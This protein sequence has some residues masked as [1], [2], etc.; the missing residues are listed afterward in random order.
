[1]GRRP[2]L[3]QHG[4]RRM[5]FALV[6]KSSW[7]KKANCLYSIFQI[8]WRNTLGL[9]GG[10]SENHFQQVLWKT[11]A[12]ESCV[13]L[14]YRIPLYLEE[15]NGVKA[16]E[17][18]VFHDDFMFAA[19]MMD[20]ENWV[21]PWAR[22]AIIARWMWKCWEKEE[23][24]ANWQM[25]MSF[26]FATLILGQKVPVYHPQILW[27]NRECIWRWSLHYFSE[28][29]RKTAEK[30]QKNWQHCLIC[31]GRSGRKWSWI[32]RYTGKTASGFHAPG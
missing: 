19:V 27:R 25:H 32:W 1:M 14:S 11:I 6:K 3:Y 15:E 22:A 7:K 21:F 13:N 30:Y 26:S 24:T 8:L 4:V 17:E 5:V 31:E 9:F 29:K 2:T 20:A 23:V 10:C 16:L 28:H 18:L 12:P